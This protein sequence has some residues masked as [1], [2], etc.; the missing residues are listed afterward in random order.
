MH[1]WQSEPAHGATGD[2]RPYVSHFLS[3]SPA[4]L[5]PTV[6]ICLYRSASPFVHPFIWW[7]IAFSVYLRLWLSLSLS[8]S[9]S[10]SLPNYLY[11][12]IHQSMYLVILLSPLINLSICPSFYHYIYRSSYPSF[13]ASHGSPTV[14]MLEPSSRNLVKEFAAKA[15]KENRHWHR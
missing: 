8:L 2:W 3:L 11:I 7:S 9:P 14:L 10:L 15:E 5:I 6:T 12:S 13:C 1:Q 4:R